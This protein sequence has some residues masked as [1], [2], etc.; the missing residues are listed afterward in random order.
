MGT[1]NLKLSTV[2]TYCKLAA[3]AGAVSSQELALV[4]SV[5]GY[6]RKEGKQIDER[7]EQANIA[8]RNGSKK[9]DVIVLSKA[10]A[11]ELKA[12]PDTPQGRR[13]RL[14][15]CLMVDLGLRR[16]E[17]AGLTVNC[18]DFQVGELTFYRQKVD[19]EQT[20]SLVNG[21]QGAMS[22]YLANDAPEGGPLLRRSRKGG[23]LTGP[24]C[25][26]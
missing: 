2:K 3:K 7:R 24:E 10:Q 5:S 25:Q 18:V 22:A 12:Q 14:L 11:D 1:V 13:D 4:R 17:V 23:H 16:S 6:S 26:R 19:K 8:T 15:V 20:H 9:R 21:L